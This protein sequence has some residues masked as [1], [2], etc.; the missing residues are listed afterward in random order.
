LFGGGAERGP[1]I[2]DRVAE[3]AQPSLHI[4]RFVGAISLADEPLQRC[5]ASR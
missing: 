4:G 1:L 2:V 3:R 5:R